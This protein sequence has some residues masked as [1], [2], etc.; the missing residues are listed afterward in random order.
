M[1]TKAQQT[2]M[3]GV[4]LVAA[5]LS[6]Q[7]HIV[8]PTSRSARGAD[9]LVTDQQC[10][11]AFSVQVKTNAQSFT[12]WLVGEQ[13]RQLAVPSHIYVLVNLRTKVGTEFYIVPSVELAPL[14]QQDN[15]KN[16][17]W[18]YV[19]RKHVTHYLNQWSPFGDPKGE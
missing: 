14:V 11:R 18:F 12:Y 1:T 19:S 4:F 13:A 16:S 10:C 9:L 6:R 5:E 3:E 7:G 2:G 15:N 17:T 8:A